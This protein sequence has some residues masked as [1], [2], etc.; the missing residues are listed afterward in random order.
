MKL[1]TN[2]SLCEQNSKTTPCLYALQT[3]SEGVRP[4]FWYAVLAHSKDCTVPVVVPNFRID[5]MNYINGIESQISCD[6][7]GIT[8]FY[9]IAFIIWMILL[10]MHLIAYCRDPINNPSI[11]LFSLS[12]AV[13]T[14]ALGF[15]AIHWISYSS[16]G[17][18]VPGLDDFA[19]VLVGI[20][21]VLYWF[22]IAFISQGYG[23][24]KAL[25]SENSGTK[26]I[27]GIM[28][29]CFGIGYLAMR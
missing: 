14:A 22:M 5:F 20:S 25:L 16:N 10:I 24:S 28:I 23:I 4:R 11:K 18:G 12:L 9:I 26:Q 21:T 8:P 13:M 27:G 6:E 17:T 2:S 7:Y 15:H 29:G 1:S 19:D 3:I